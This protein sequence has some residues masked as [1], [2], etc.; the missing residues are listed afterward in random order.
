MIRFNC[1]DNDPFVNVSS[2]LFLFERTSGNK[3]DRTVDR[4]RA[5]DEEIKSFLSR[6]TIAELLDDVFRRN[7]LEIICCLYESDKC[8]DNSFR[9]RIC[10]AMPLRRSSTGTVA[11]PTLWHE[12]ISKYSHTSFRT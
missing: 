2:S 7:H 10:L 3:R 8:S 5:F 1:N 9:S 4:K 12:S 11:K 6:P